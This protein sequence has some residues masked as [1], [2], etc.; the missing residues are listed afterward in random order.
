MNEHQKWLARKMYHETFSATP[1]TFL[2]WRGVPNR[3]ACGCGEVW[4][5]AASPVNWWQYLS[6]RLLFRIQFLFPVYR[7][8]FSLIWSCPPVIWTYFRLLRATYKENIRF[9]VGSTNHSAE[10][11]AIAIGRLILYG[12]I[13]PLVVLSWIT[14]WVLSRIAGIVIMAAHVGSLVLV[15]ALM[16]FLLGIAVIAISM[17]GLVFVL[18][19]IASVTYS[20]YPAVGIA[21]IVAGVLIEYERNRRNE[22]QKEEQLGH[23]MLTL[24]TYEKHTAKN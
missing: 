3:C 7:A 23:L 20:Y 15:M 4:F 8:L 6:P 17:R 21:L 19:G 22:R 11:A 13:A 2:K 9:K 16:M 1:P 10:R 24:E 18:G 14:T 5:D 12:V